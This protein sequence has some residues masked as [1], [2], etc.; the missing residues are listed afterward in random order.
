MRRGVKPCACTEG[1]AC[2]TYVY[3]EWVGTKR[4][5]LALHVNC[6]AGFYLAGLSHQKIL[7]FLLSDA[8]TATICI[9]SISQ[10]GD[11]MMNHFNSNN[12]Y[13]KHILLQQH[14]CLKRG[15]L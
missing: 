12:L 15:L 11:F 4:C 8:K 5:H 9:V 6:H 3:S 14:F 13:K 2:W 1:V 7:Q 10:D